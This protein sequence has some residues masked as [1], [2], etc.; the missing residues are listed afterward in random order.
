MMLA[1]CLLGICLDDFQAINLPTNVEFF[2]NLPISTIP[3]FNFTISSHP[4]AIAT[5]ITMSR[6]LPLALNG[7]LFD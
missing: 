1:A 6:P 5:R 2:N 3:D 4:T 7:S